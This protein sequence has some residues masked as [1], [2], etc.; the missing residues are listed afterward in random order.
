MNNKIIVPTGYSGSGSSA[1]TDLVS[2]LE[3]F[4]ENLGS[5]EF[6]FTHCP[7]GLFDLEDKLLIGNNGLRSDEAIH[8]FLSCM[9]RLH[10]ERNYWFSDYAVKVTPRFYSFCEEMIA[11]LRLISMNDVY[12]YY[13]ENI[14]TI[15]LRLLWHIRMSA[16][17]L[18]G[19]HFPKDKPFKPLDYDD[20]QL[21]YPKPDEFYAAARRMLQK[22]YCELG[23]E[24]HPLV[25]D[26][27]L[28]PHNLHRID[29]YF[30]DRLRVFVV[31]RDPRDVYL[32]NKYYWLPAHVGVP[33]PTEPEAFCRVYAA[34]RQSERHVEDSRILRLHFED[35]IYRYDE[36]CRRV[37]AFLDVSDAQHARRKGTMFQPDKS[38]RN[39]QLF[40][41]GS[42]PAEDL[43][44][45]EEQ[46]SGYL[47]DFPADVPV[48]GIS[49][50]IF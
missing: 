32:L 22:L 31:D 16:T 29:R 21:A 8:S 10:H 5:F 49:D 44:I 40:R 14:D 2:E 9:Y 6:V 23:C 33:F 37:Y 3:G 39:T 18:F 19:R 28:L 46:L 25:L 43:H 20:V 47:Y 12:W 41:R 24:Q 13:Q 45:I 30:D 42:F 48:P 36:T 38:I 27:L 15:P 7:N 17:K 26:Q 1:L 50:D 4:D 34:M 35:C 11:D